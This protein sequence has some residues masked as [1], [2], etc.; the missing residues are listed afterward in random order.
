VNITRLAEQS[1]GGGTSINEAV[2][3][4]NYEGVLFLGNV[5]TTGTALTLTAAHGASTT[6]FVNLTGGTHATTGGN[7][8]A[9]LDVYRPR[10]RYVRC[11]ASTTANAR[12]QL[13]AIQYSS[14]TQLAS[15]AGTLVVSPDT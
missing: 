4:A 11:T 7:D 3:M 1:T 15:T 6:G 13:F 10:K 12:I 8:I 9:Q 2:D 5:G 14:R